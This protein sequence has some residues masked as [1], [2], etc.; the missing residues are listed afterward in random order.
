L[1]K[2]RRFKNAKRTAI[3][4]KSRKTEVAGGGQP[5]GM[6][7]VFLKQKTFDVYEDLRC[8]GLSQLRKF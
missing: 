6:E 4:Y 5:T 8:G 1:Q 3:N 7:E 2:I